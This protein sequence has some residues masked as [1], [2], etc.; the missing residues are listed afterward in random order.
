[1]ELT[2]IKNCAPVLYLPF[3]DGF[4]IMDDDFRSSLIEDINEF[5][6]TPI[7]VIS[8]EH[9]NTLHEVYDLK[10]LKFLIHNIKR[11]EEF[12]TEIS[13]INELLKEDLSNL[14]LTKERSIFLKMLHVVSNEKT[15]EL[16]GRYKEYYENVVRPI[17]S[18]VL[19]FNQQRIKINDKKLLKNGNEKLKEFIVFE[20]GQCYLPLHVN[21]LES[22]TGRL[23][24][25]IY[26]QLNELKPYFI[27]EENSRIIEIDTIAAEWRFLLYLSDN[28]D[29]DIQGKDYWNDLIKE[30]QLDEQITGKLLK[31]ILY[32]TIYGAGLNTISET[33]KLS[34]EIIKETQRILKN[35]FRKT[36]DFIQH[37]NKYFSKNSSITYDYCAKEMYVENNYTRLNYVLQSS[38]STHFMLFVNKVIQRIKE[39]GLQS[40][41]LFTVHDSLIVNLNLIEKE[42]F[43]TIL[44][45]TNASMNP[46]FRFTIKK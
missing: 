36:F 39:E 17:Y 2:L 24:S 46:S 4:S 45:E 13:T 16:L 25:N 28:L 44:N 29:K 19:H 6:D 9:F 40:K 22:E 20:D 18:N 34:E 31:S 37:D 35:Y 12:E 33:T 30:L 42:Q 15:R 14:T 3:S 21:C 7:V 41:I 8:G 1:M 10:F 23:N 11:D 5:S 43:F 26:S 27:A 38:L 32:P